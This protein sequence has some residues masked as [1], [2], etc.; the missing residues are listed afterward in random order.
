MIANGGGA[1][2]GGEGG[3]GAGG[4]WGRPVAANSD[5]N[6]KANARSA[7]ESRPVGNKMLQKVGQ[8]GTSSECGRRCRV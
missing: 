5:S 7:E 2:V 6:A 1:A 3:K 8:V 4:W